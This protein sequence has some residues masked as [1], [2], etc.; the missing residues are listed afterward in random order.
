MTLPVVLYS[1]APFFRNAWRDMRMLRAGMD[2]PVALGIVAAFI[3]SAWSTLGGGGPVYYD[4]VTMFVAL[5]LVGRLFELR[6]R[7]AAAEAIEAVSREL[8][9]LA[10]R[11]AAY[12][13]PGE[14]AM[15]AAGSLHIGDYVRVQVGGVVPAD[16]VVVEGRSSVE[17][18]L[19]TGESWP[20]IKSAGDGVLAG[21]INRESPLI[22]RVSAAG[23]D[24]TA[25]ALGRLVE[26]AANARPRIARIADQVASWFIVA[27]LAMATLAAA[28]W[29]RIDPTRAIAVIFA[30]LVVSCPCA[31]SLATP[32]A[33]ASAAGA[34]ARR[35]ILAVR[36]DALETLSRVTHVVMDKTGTL[37]CGRPQLIDLVA[38]GARGAG[39]CLAIACA[40]ERGSSHPIAT[41]LL[42]FADAGVSAEDVVAVAGCGVEG[43][44]GGRLYRLG[45]PGWAGEVFD[46]P[47]TNA[48][49]GVGDERIAIMLAGEEGWLARMTFGDALRPGAKEA[50]AALR[51]MGIGVSLVSGDRA[52]TVR[53]VA[54][55]V[56][57]D[58]AVAEAKPE[59]KWTAIVSM[60]RAGAVVAMVGDGVNDAPALAQANVSLAFGSAATLTRWTADVVALGGDVRLVVDAIAVAR[61]AYRVIRQNL[62]WAVAYNAVAIPLAAFGLITPLA[63]ALGM[64]VSS[65]LVVLNA[66]RLLRQPDAAASAPVM[67]DASPATAAA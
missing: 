6:S 59:Q 56:G 12:P 15:V 19:L 5:L 43:T 42:E 46:A 29:W 28:V 18:A 10:E 41:A 36:A 9:S 17:E 2:V 14:S 62:L 11:I 67:H 26:R 66:L 8:P 40:L 44:I 21:S 50:V 47:L 22:V 32:A 23:A 35:R 33:L 16:G 27:L 3:A 20:R 61:R 60:Q 7:Q 55:A 45:E 4:S 38:V 37:T 13:A 39:E 49:R 48:L 24:T 53:H 30:M 51:A 54:D 65:S 58:D 52:A 34:L 63:A 64:S 57:I 31:M 1:A 25:A